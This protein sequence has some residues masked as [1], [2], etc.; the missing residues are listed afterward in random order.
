MLG[1]ASGIL[2]YIHAINVLHPCGACLVRYNS[3]SCVYRLIDAWRPLYQPFLMLSLSIS[4]V[5]VGLPGLALLTSRSSCV[6]VLF[7]CRVEGLR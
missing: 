3:W 7:G 1:L 5:H 2:T 6:Q 4:L